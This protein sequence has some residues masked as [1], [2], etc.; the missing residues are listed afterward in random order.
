MF[1][2]IKAKEPAAETTQSHDQESSF[3]DISQEVH[4]RLEDAQSAATNLLQQA[5]EAS[6]RLRL[7]A[8]QQGL[9]RAQQTIEQQVQNE[10]DTR[11]ETVLPA[12]QTAIESIRREQANHL[13]H[14]EQQVVQLAIAIA[15]RLVR[16]ELQRKPE[17]AVD[18][19][20]E[21]LDLAAGCER[22]KLH[23]NPAD[24]ETLG[25]RMVQAARDLRESTLTDIIPDPQVTRGGCIVT[26][27]HGVIDQ[28][29]ETQLARIEEELI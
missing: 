20:R 16:R 23:L 11:L 28:R 7:E 6:E 22:I 21:A 18:L 8:E 9:R 12:L 27:E 17:I 26:T 19:V 4:A 24:H 5:R 10:L 15:Q 29:V 25:D 3:V 2:I 1:R 13:K 14:C